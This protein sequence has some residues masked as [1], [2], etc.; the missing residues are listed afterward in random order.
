MSATDWVAIAAGFAGIA[1]VNWYF[2]AAGRGAATV[3]GSE[4]VIV[5]DGGY[6]PA[7]IRARAGEQLRLVFDRRDT[8]S[9]SEEVVFPDFGVRKFLPHGERTTI[10]ITPP[11][12][13][14][15]EFMCGM[16]MLRGTVIAE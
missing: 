16:S 4:V 15:Y 10:E 12:P 8:S 11:T 7:T 5:V 1:L 3:T 2:F 14:R 6:S 13:G 9:C